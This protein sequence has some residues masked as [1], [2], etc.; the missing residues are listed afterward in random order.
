MGMI[1]STQ[2]KSVMLDLHNT[3]LCMQICKGNT[4]ILVV[5][6]HEIV[7]VVDRYL[8][9]D[10]GDPFIKLAKVFNNPEQAYNEWLHVVGKMC[11]KECTSKYFDKPKISD[12]LNNGKFPDYMKN[13]IVNM[14]KAVVIS[15]NELYSNDIF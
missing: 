4:T 9:V 2:T 5:Q 10:G 13:V 7:V 6:S 8:T 11:K 1:K 15:S 12:H 14:A 3:V